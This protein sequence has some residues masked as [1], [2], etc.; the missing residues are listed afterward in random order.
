MP[1]LGAATRSLLPSS[2][3]Y[4]FQDVNFETY[5]NS[6]LFVYELPF[7]LVVVPDALG[8]LPDLIPTLF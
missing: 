2:S 5:H 7:P 3:Y 1:V 4:S 8:E 6:L